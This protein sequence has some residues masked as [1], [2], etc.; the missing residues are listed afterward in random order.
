M[1]TAA[2]SQDAIISDVTEE[3]TFSAFASLNNLVESN[4]EAKIRG[5]RIGDLVTEALKPMLREW[6]DAN[7]QGIVEH[8]VTREV[9]RISSGK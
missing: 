1:P 9:Q 8:A 6:L 7:L 5:D 2:V 3:A 4:T